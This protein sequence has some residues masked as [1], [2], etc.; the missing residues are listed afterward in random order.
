MNVLELN[1]VVGIRGVLLIVVVVVALGMLLRMVRAWRELS[2]GQKLFLF[3]TW[4]ILIYAGDAMRAAIQAGLEW[5]WRL[6][7]G[8]FGAAALF[9]W[10]LEPLDLQKRLWGRPSFSKPPEHDD[11]DGSSRDEQ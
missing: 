2:L 7:P 10:L 6:I 5:R 8:L 4:C 3:G 1:H 11:D 9:G